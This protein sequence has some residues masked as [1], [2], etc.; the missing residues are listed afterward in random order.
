MHQIWLNILKCG[1]VLL[2][3]DWLLS[4]LNVAA[5]ENKGRSKQVGDS[6]F[7]T[8]GGPKANWGGPKANWGDLGNWWKLEKQGINY[9]TQ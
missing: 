5:K 3:Y 6:T 2:R 9:Q 8:R 7:V 1:Y 4:F